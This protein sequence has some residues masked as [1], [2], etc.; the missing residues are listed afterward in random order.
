MAENLHFGLVKISQ[1]ANVN[2]VRVAQRRLLIF[3][4]QRLPNAE[5]YACSLKEYG[6]SATE[7]LV[8][9]W[10]EARL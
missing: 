5:F 4:G 6:S 2:I 3:E 9:F 10:P 7:L 1:S 8:V